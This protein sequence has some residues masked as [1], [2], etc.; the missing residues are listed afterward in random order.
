MLSFWAI[1]IKQIILLYIKELWCYVG[2][3][4]QW[5]LFTWKRKHN[6]SAYHRVLLMAEIKWSMSQKT[7]DLGSYSFVV[8]S[9]RLL[10]TL[11]RRLVHIKGSILVN[12]HS[13]MVN[14][15]YTYLYLHVRLLSHYDINHSH[16][17]DLCHYVLRI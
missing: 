3:M 15:H 7:N 4:Y 5:Q 6:P 13:Q 11:L 1:L 16:Q 2:V 8:Y 14:A 12:I 9:W 10:Y 17:V